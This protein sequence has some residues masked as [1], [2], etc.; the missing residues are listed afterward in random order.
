MAVLAVDGHA[1]APRYIA[2]NLIAGDGVA[3]LGDIGHQIADPHYPYRR[4][5]R[6]GRG[7]FG[8]QYRFFLLGGQ[9]QDNLMGC[10]AAIADRRQKVVQAAVSKQ[11]GQYL[12]L[13]LYPQ[14]SQFLIQ[15]L[16]A[17][18]D[19]LRPLLLIEPLPYFCLG[20]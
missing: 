7:D 14:A 4:R 1:A 20:V 12:A 10:D 19:V 2:D 8:H 15:N 5:R 11:F 6:F 9:L 3:A 18:L 13:G 17:A 16:P